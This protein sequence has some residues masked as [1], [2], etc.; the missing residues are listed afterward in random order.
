MLL[1]FIKNIKNKYLIK[2]INSIKQL[3]HSIIVDKYFM[4]FENSKIAI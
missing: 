3:N 2:F 4:Q 1:I